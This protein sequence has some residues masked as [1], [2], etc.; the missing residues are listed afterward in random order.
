[1]EFP[2]FEFAT[3]N[4][5]DVREEI[6][7]P[8]LRRLGYRSGT[9]NNVIREQALS[10]PRN[11][12]GR[13]KNSDPILRGR[14]DYLCVA[15]GRVKWVI[16]AKAPDAELTKEVE[17]QSWSYANHP[18]IRAVYFCLT[19]GKEF[20]VFQTNKGAEAGAIFHCKYE[21]IPSSLII[22]E[23][24][25]SPDSILRDH[26]ELEIDTRPPLGPGLRSLVRITNGL[27]T[28]HGNT[29]DLQPLT[30][31]NITVT[32][33]SVERNENNKLEAYIETTV[34][35]QSLQRLN[36]KL[37]LHSL[38]LLNEDG[39]LSTNR[40]TP[41]TFVSTSYHVLPAG[42][43]VLNLLTWREEPFPMNIRTRVVTMASGHLD[44]STFLGR[45]DAELLYEE[46]KFSVGLAGSFDMHLA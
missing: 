46:L 3:M 15:K 33:G 2:P 13:K 37:G 23:N 38:R 41:S 26:P 14:A 31:L 40:A 24:I 27:I 18:E 28:F 29:L 19:N 9:G 35:Y 25:L 45:F 32:Q 6:V 30:G 11:F 4:E 7:A 39:S 10:Y 5:S 1:M 44:G 36:E 21:Q 43:P 42:E 12:L 8:L 22:I 34:P 17:E 16:E 20:K